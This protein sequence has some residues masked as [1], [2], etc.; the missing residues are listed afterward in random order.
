MRTILSLPYLDEWIYSRWTKNFTHK[1]Q[2]QE[3]TIA[4]LIKILCLWIHGNFI[5][6]CGLIQNA[7][8]LLDLKLHYKI[9]NQI[10]SFLKYCSVLIKIVASRKE[11]LGCLCPVLRVASHPLGLTVSAS[12]PGCVV[13]PTQR[14][15]VS[16]P[17]SVGRRV[18][19]AR[20]RLSM[21]KVESRG[22]S[23]SNA[24]KLCKCILNSTDPRGPWNI[25]L[26][27]WHYLTK[28]YSL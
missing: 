28:F 18:K 22:D 27:N 9:D 20:G 26:V 24:S 7:D 25:C 12:S 6:S 2:Q 16:K 4:K 21:R 1:K 14:E 19:D 17:H 13:F 11:L 5:Q 15:R 23:F 8:F 10:A 3:I